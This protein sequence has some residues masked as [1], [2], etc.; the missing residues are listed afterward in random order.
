MSTSNI[1]Q[2]TTDD[3]QIKW[4]KQEA[5][6]RKR[7]EAMAGMHCTVLTKGNIALVK[8]RNRRPK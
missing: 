4:E 7:L 8:V 5:D 1:S 6:H 2:I 3:L